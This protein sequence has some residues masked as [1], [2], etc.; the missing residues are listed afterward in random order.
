MKIDFEN[1]MSSIHHQNSNRPFKFPPGHAILIR[2]FINGVQ[3][4]HKT[5]T[6]RPLELS[7]PKTSKKQRTKQNQNESNEDHEDDDI[8]L[9]IP[10]D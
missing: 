6:K 4:K 2:K 10:R 8:A 5:K 3:E 7:E 1:C 9:I